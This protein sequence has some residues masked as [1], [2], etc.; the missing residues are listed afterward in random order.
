[1]LPIVDYP[2]IVKNFLPHFQDLFSKPQLRQFAESLTGIFVCNKRNVKSMN[3]VFLGHRDQSAKNRFFNFSNWDEKELNKRRIEL[4]LKKVKGIGIL[5][6]DD[7]LLHKSGKKIYGVGKFY[8]CTKHCYTLAQQLVTG[9]FISN[10]NFA[11][12][13]R[14]YLKK[15]SAE[16]FKGKI[17]LAKELI[18]EAVELGI[19]FS[20]AVADS[21]YFCKKL[22]EF[23]EN[24]G[25]SWVF[26]CKSNRIIIMENK[27]IQLSEYEKNL[28]LKDFKEVEIKGKLYFCLAK[29]FLMS[30]QGK[31][32][33]LICYDGEDPEPKFIATN[34]LDW[35]EKKILST[36]LKRWQIETFYRGAKQ[37]LG[38][39]ECQLRTAKGTSR[40]WYLMFLA[41]TLLKISSGFSN[42]IR[43]FETSFDTVGKKCLA[44][45]FEVLENFLSWAFNQRKKLKDLGEILKRAFASNQ[46]LKI[47]SIKNAKL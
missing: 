7:I 22:T 26:G 41:D 36:Y 43:W 39:E 24:L 21:W 9:Q 12:D 46:E 45:S 38:W 17:D 23:I 1:M 37:N 8:D 30:N 14:Q 31:V 2:S 34:H 47:L 6:I 13:F 11:I 18:R 35:D 3:D 10:I 29:N 5:A 28:Q 27:K 42:L 32:R 16:I 44:L 15:E 20:D 25:K 19:P 33:V 4:A 40:T